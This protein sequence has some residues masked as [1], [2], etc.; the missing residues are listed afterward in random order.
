MTVP[1]Y[2]AVKY[3]L[4]DAYPDE[5]DQPTQC[6]CESIVS[7]SSP[8]SSSALP[9][10]TPPFIVHVELTSLY[11]ASIVQQCVDRRKQFLWPTHEQPSSAQLHLQLV[12][13]EQLAWESR[14]SMRHARTRA[15]HSYSPLINAFPIRKGLIRKAQL[16][17]QL[18][19]YMCKR[20]ES[21][22]HRSIPYTLLMSIDDPE[23]LSEAL[24]ECY[25]VRDMKEGDMWIMKASMIDGAQG[26]HVIRSVADVESIVSDPAHEDI[27]EWILQQYIQRP[28][29]HEGA[30]FHLR[31]YCLCV[32]NL[33]VYLYSEALVLLAVEAYDV[34]S[35]SVH[36]HITN[37]CRN[38]MHASFEEQK[39]IKLLHD[40]FNAEQVQSI[41]SQLQQCLHDVFA[42]LH[43]E[44]TVFLPLPNAFELYGMDFLVDES[45]QVWFLEANAGPDFAMT[46]DRLQCLIRG[47]M[48][49]TFRSATQSLSC[50]CQRVFALAECSVHCVLCDSL[51]VDPY[52]SKICRELEL[53]LP[54]PSLTASSDMIGEFIECYRCINLATPSMKYY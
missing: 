32:G 27:K 5:P 34:R 23:Y 25:E 20:A 36:A 44:P 6:P 13:Y 7:S 53:P 16:A 3:I 41:R 1:S 2:I 14:Y 18:K 4:W 22:L 31:V 51:A 33:T 52:C 54:Q 10:V 39:H 43:A 11:T 26:I 42:A 38:Q 48:E 35:H 45:L 19:K 8:S 47:L 37:T 15:Q 28:F 21:F 40:I 50:V 29:L 49:H 9:A 24:N 46:G 17:Y 30:K 12:E